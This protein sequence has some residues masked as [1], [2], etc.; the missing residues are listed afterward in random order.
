[1]LRW[2]N[3]K[4]NELVRVLTSP[5]M[6]TVALQGVVSGLVPGLIGGSLLQAW[7]SDAGVDIKTIGLLTAVATPYTLKFLW[8]P[9]LDRFTLPLGRRKGAILLSQLLLLVAV[10]F[11]STLDP[12]TGVQTIAVTAVVIAFLGATLDIALDAWRREY[13]SDS[14]IALGLSANTLAFLISFRLITGSLALILADHMSWAHVYQIM[15]LCI[16]PSMISI[17]FSTEPVTDVPPPKRFYESVALP[18]IDFFQRQGALFLILFILLYK[19]GDNMGSALTTKFYLDLGYTKTEIGLIGKWAGWIAIAGG[20]LVG[21]V[22]MLRMRIRNALFIFGIFQAISTACFALL[23]MVPHHILALGSIIAFENFTAGLGTAAFSTLIARLTN[24]KFT[25]TQY[26]LLTS[27][28]GVPR[29]L[30]GTPTG[31]LVQWMGWAAFFVFCG[32]VAVPGIL[33]SLKIKEDEQGAI[34]I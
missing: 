3:M 24:K 21:G 33:L 23:A 18:F 6:L 14:E 12:K 17:F 11:M 20:S 2:S 28:M 13:L 4:T 1:M 34:S 22:L 9:L 27:A 25:A 30:S 10:G 26:A 19:L 8:A 31:Y 29:Y 5:R 32:V 15:G 7:V 16:V